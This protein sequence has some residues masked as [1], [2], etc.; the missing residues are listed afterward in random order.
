MSNQIGDQTGAGHLYET[1]L[2]RLTWTY[3]L[4]EK[5]RACLPYSR[6]MFA[7][8]TE[9]VCRRRSV[10]LSRARVNQGA[11]SL[12]ELVGILQRSCICIG[13]RHGASSSS[14]HNDNP[15]WRCSAVSSPVD[16][17][18]KRLQE[19]HRLVDEVT[20]RDKIHVPVQRTGIN[21]VIKNNSS[22]SSSSTCINFLFF[23]FR[24]HYLKDA[25]RNKLR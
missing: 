12:M 4:H 7:L 11:N 8:F 18:M 1:G 9:H 21:L 14:D 6:S 10:S 20:E 22:S 3:L 5:D 17:W 13:R 15:V 2:F 19:A 23:S 25:N 24:A 16:Q